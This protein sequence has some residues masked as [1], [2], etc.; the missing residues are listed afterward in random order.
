MYPTTPELY[1]CHRGITVTARFTIWSWNSNCSLFTTR[2]RKLDVS[3][4]VL[5]L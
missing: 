3:W 4:L 1:N 5:V 2:L